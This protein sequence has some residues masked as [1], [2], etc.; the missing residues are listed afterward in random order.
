M[1]SAPQ[2]AQMSRLLDEALTLDLEARRRWLQDL[3]PEHRELEPAL[4]RVLLPEDGQTSGPEAS[5][6]LPGLGAQVQTASIG[7]GL[8][9]GQAVDRYRLIRPLGAGGMAEVWLAERADGAFKREVALK[10]PTLWRYRQD[11]ASR[12]ARER[13]ILAGLEHPNIARLYDAGV[14]AEGLPYLAMEYVHGE[15]LT[16]WCNAHRVGIRERLKLFL[17]VL[18]AVQ[19]A[20]ERQVIHRDIKPSNILATESGQVRLLDFGVAKLLAQE[21]DRTDLT[22]LYG[23]ALTPEYASPEQVR[24]EPIDVAADVYSLG[25]L[26]YELLCG[27]RPYRLK[28]GSSMLQVEQAIQTAQVERP[29]TRIGPDAGVDRGTSQDKLAKRLRGDLDAIVLK[30]LAKTPADRYGSVAA[31]ADDVQRYL[32]DEPVRARPAS[33]SYMAGKF[34]QRQRTVVATTVAFAA[35]VAAVIGYEAKRSPSADHPVP[36]IASVPPPNTATATNSDKFI[37]V[38]PFP[39]VDPGNRPGYGSE[40]ARD[41]SAALGRTLAHFAWRV[42][43]SPETTQPGPSEMRRLGHELNASHLISGE[44]RHA[45]DKIEVDMQ[46]FDGASGEEIWSDRLGAPIAKLEQF[47]NLMVLKATAAL[48]NALYNIEQRRVLNTSIDRLNPSELVMRAIANPDLTDED[49]STIERL[50]AEARRRDPNNVPALLGWAFHLCSLQVLDKAGDH[51]EKLLQ[52][53]DDLSERALRLAPNDAI[54]YHVRAIVFWRQL[55]IG[56][57]L[58]ANA[59]AIE[60]DPSNAQFYVSRAQQTMTVGKPAAAIPMLDLARDV[61]PSVDNYASAMACR[62][63]LQLGRYDEAVQNCERAVALDSS[64]FF[65]HLFLT[66]AYAQKGDLARAAEAREGLL[67]LKPGLTLKYFDSDRPRADLQRFADQWDKH[68]IAGLRKAGVPER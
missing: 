39:A 23:Q 37:V 8:K 56:A 2:M 24:G 62:A 34:V 63:H 50:L 32:N 28:P 52:E 49:R 20:H 11:L 43:A 12:F 60:L 55:R 29:S 46:I 35:L 22:Q 18:E 48:R 3:A 6:T 7:T 4:R 9:P 47:P 36:A 13:D 40:F 27:S 61:D 64:N 5:V 68:V 66:A 19:Y 33:L 67:R 42:I 38:L 65:V 26:L 54:G 17:Q 25:V 58:A 57:A 44:V 14:S 53:A 31:L 51:S 30:A 45:S 10:L 21:D 59:K 16:L 15:P 1:L 41:L